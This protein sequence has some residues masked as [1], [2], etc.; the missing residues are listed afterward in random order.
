[1]IRRIF[2]RELPEWIGWYQEE[3]EEWSPEFQT[4]ESYLNFS[5]VSCL[6]TR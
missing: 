3:E 4:L 1:M 5:S 6:L 2:K